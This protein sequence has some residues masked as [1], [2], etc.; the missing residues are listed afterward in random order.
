MSGTSIEDEP[1]ARRYLSEGQRTVQGW[2][3]DTAANI[4]VTLL[5]EQQRIGIRGGICEI[6]VHHGRLFILLHLHSRS[7]ERS[8]AIDLF[9]NQADNVDRSGFGDREKLLENL[10]RHGGD[11]SRVELLAANSLQ[12]VPE[13]I[14]SAVG[15][16]RVFSVDGGHTADVT[17]HD[18]ELAAA[19]SCDGGLVIL[20]DFF[21]E[22]WPGVA[23][24]ACRFM[25]ANRGA[26]MPV[27]IG[28]NKFVFA[29]GDATPYQRA[30][31]GEP[32]NAFG[33][34]VICVH[35]PSAKERLVQMAL[36]RT[37]RNTRMGGWVRRTLAWLP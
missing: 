20:D 34:P 31:R 5:R 36:W 8:L 13:Q 26:L 15:P 16:V 4:I 27:A 24:G 35:T 21:N 19:S 32:S 33:H 9:E 14:R 12:I 29:R 25:F 30:L 1:K 7:D 23:E 3:P 2:L 11:L 18:L 10:A 6:G 22:R 28:G 17:E 37:I